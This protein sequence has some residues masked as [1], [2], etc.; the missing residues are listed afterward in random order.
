M[1]AVFDKYENLLNQTDPL[2]YQGVVKR[3]VSMVI[4]AAGPVSDLGELCEIYIPG[5]E[6]VRAEVIGFK[7]DAVLLMAYDSIDGISPGCGIKA[8]G[9][10]VKVDITEALLGRII[11]GLGEPLDGIPRVVSANPYGIFRSPTNALQRPIID[12]PLSV[13]IR[14]IDGCLTLGRGQR[15]GIFSGS[16]V[17]KSTLLGMIARNTDADIN[18]VG[19]IGE[20]GREV[21]EFIENDLGPEGLK[22][23]VVVAATSDDSPL[24]KLRAAYVATTIAEYFRDQG[25]DV[26]LMMDSVT[27]FARA[28]REIGLAIG[29]P[30][31]SMGS[32]PPSVFDMLAKI[33][34]RAGTSRTGS[35]TGIYTV[36]VESDDI[37]DPI[38]DA[39]RGILDGHIVLSRNLA[40]MNH[41]PA[42]DVLGSISR[43]MTKIADK[44]QKSAA[45]KLREVLAIYKE[46]EDL[47]TA[48][49]YQAGTDPQV[50]NAI[51]MR[52]AVNLFLKQGIDENSSFS[53][54]KSRLE[55]LFSS[56]E[57]F[58]SDDNKNSNLRQF[59]DLLE[60]INN[61]AL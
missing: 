27:R 13:G 11:N 52:E 48:G 57:N 15:I 23:S 42:I 33:L 22:R 19:L 20:R 17:G 7:D 4:E 51:K 16:G 50:D 41:Y 31:S 43:L 21:K 28:Q 38:S 53:D 12:K 30:P 6:P 29:E 46:K 40:E 37:N 24:A 58:G 5:R 26:L 25:K 14:A 47:I 35:I 55:A 9:T 8:L 56:S 18:V 59:D 1:T 49:V 54:T 39:V 34:E 10:S 45:A 3:V 2:K 44:S 36:L 32:F 60:R 61:E